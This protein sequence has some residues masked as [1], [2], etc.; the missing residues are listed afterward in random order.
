MIEQKFQEL[1]ALQ[2][3]QALQRI[4]KD[5]EKLHG[6]IEPPKRRNENGASKKKKSNIKTKIIN[7]TDRRGIIL[8]LQ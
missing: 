6:P 8:H 3:L 2:Q 7:E 1:Q 5:F 4:V